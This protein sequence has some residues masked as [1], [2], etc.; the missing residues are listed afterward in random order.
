[1]HIAARVNILTARVTIT[2][3]NTPTPWIL[4]RNI[5]TVPQCALA[6]WSLDLARAKSAAY[7]L[8]PSVDVKPVAALLTMQSTPSNRSM[9][10]L[11]NLRADVSGVVLRRAK[12]TFEQPVLE[13]VLVPEIS[14]GQMADSP[15]TH[16]VQHGPGR[17]AVGS[18]H[19]PY[20]C[21]DPDVVQ[22][23]QEHVLDGEAPA[24]YRRRWRGI[25]SRPRRATQ[26]SG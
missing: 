26:P 5:N 9:V 23:L 21:S 24:L 20:L 15:A 4:S 3:Y 6:L 1:M 17:V 2:V 7:P 18:L 10:L 25:R 11:F 14:R 12:L 13:R 22:N 16:S 8:C 19:S